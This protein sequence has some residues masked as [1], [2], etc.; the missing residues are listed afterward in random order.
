MSALPN[1]EDL[2]VGRAISAA[3][4]QELRRQSLYGLPPE[5]AQLPVMDVLLPYQKQAIQTRLRYSVTFIEKSRRT[6]LTW[7]FALDAVL[8]AA[9][10]A[11]AGGMDAWYIG[12]NLEMAR[13]FID[14]V[15]MWAKLVADVAIEAA[16][17]VFEDYDPQTKETR[18]IKAF[19][20]R[21]ASGFEVVAL[22]S[23]PRS[24]R[25]KAGYVLIDEAAFHDDLDE[26]M[27]AAV[28]LTIWGGMVVVISTHD[29][30][31]N[32]FNRR[33]EDIRAGRL[34]YGLVRI[35]F[36]DALRGGL[37]Q[38]ICQRKGEPWDVGKEA[39]WREGIIAD[40]AEAADEELFCIPSEGSG[41]WILPGVIDACM[42]AEIPVIRWEMPT[43]FAAQPEAIREAA[44]L[45]FCVHQIGP[46]LSRLSPD[47]RSVFGLDFGRI[48]D[49]SVLWPHQVQAGLYLSTP[50]VVEMRNIPFAQ[51]EQVVVWIARRLPRLVKAAIDAG[52]NGAALAEKAAQALG[53]GLVEQIKFSVDWYRQN[54]P[55]Y[56][57]TLEARGASVPKDADIRADFSIIKMVDGVARPSALR[58]TAKGE[59]AADGKKRKRHG[60]AAVAGALAHFAAMQ[61]W[62]EGRV[63]VLDTPR[64]EPMALGGFGFGAQMGAL[65]DSVKSFM[66]GA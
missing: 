39:A 41:V 18:Q 22:P 14:V 25:G 24:L 63:D 60:D 11:K 16:E 3:E 48:S 51:Q 33:I 13:E 64:G 57:R 56:K 31:G 20:V 30:Q 45:D 54:M 17:Y 62:G 53:F 12:Y 10:T 66:K 52:G 34:P 50:F 19:R 5:L 38:R 65:I 27:K 4:W 55:P 21:F 28:A 6:G 42:E 2:R 29:G 9:A 35:D 32:A 8:V 59:Q 15:G 40:Y 26:L 43:E 36:D 44:A 49:L 1:S 46:H 37:Y 58:T 47:Y 23:S 7:A 61:P